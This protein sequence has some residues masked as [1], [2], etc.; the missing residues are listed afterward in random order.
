MKYFN[1]FTL[2]ALIISTLV[3]CSNDN[4]LYN[5]GLSSEL[6]SISPLK[7]TINVATQQQYQAFFYNKLSIQEDVSNSTLWSVDKPELANINNNGLL[8][9]KRPGTVII[10]GKFNAFTAKATLIITDKK[11]C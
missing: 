7:E 4:P 10:T 9:A 8:T 11:W 3:A 5:E 6:Y 2:A 1:F